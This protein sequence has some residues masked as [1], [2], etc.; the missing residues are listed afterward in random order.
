MCSF[1]EEV[2]FEVCG[3]MPLSCESLQVEWR[4]DQLLSHL[5]LQHCH[6]LKGK[7][8]NIIA[9]CRYEESV[10]YRSF[11]KTESPLA[12]KIKD[13]LPLISLKPPLSLTGA[14]TPQLAPS[15]VFPK[16]LSPSKCAKRERHGK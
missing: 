8:K 2:S 3:V 7:E 12:L 11:H 1:R 4:F 16:G 6:K 10:H 14:H 15:H 5:Q 13:L 9:S